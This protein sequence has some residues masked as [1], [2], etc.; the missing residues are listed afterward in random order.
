M[1][2]IDRQVLD[3]LEL[4]AA[5][6]PLPGPIQAVHNGRAPDPVQVTF[7]PCSHTGHPDR[8]SKGCERGVCTGSK[9]LKVNDPVLLI[10][11]PDCFNKMIPTHRVK[12]TG[13]PTG[14]PH[15]QFGKAIF[16]GY[17]R[18]VLGWRLC[19]PMLDVG[20]PKAAAGST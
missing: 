6:G 4:A 2:W 8:H 3:R 17:E 11:D 5:A 9:A 7:L 20:I 18:L 14:S 19:R 16:D 13:A 1:V 12:H 15:T 10:R